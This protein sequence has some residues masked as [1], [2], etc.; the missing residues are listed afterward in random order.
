MTTNEIIDELLELR[1]DQDSRAA[2]YK[3]SAT[4]CRKLDQPDLTRQYDKRSAIAA[5]R[6]EALEAAVNHIRND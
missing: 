5:R 4:V 2:Q 3:E 6:A 1:A